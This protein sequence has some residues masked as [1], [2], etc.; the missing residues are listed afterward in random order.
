MRTFLIATDFSEASRN[1]TRYGLHLAKAMQ[2]KV[3]LL[4][5]YQVPLP[6]PGSMV[7]IT[8]E[9]M[10]QIAAQHM[11][12]EAAALTADQIHPFETKCLQGVPADAIAAYADE[13]G[14]ELIIAGMKG[15]GKTIRRIFGSTAAALAKACNISVLVV[16]EGAA[17]TVPEQ[18]VLATDFSGDMDVH[19]LD[20]LKSIATT[21]NSRLYIVRVVKNKAEEWQQVL[22]TPET[23]KLAV[24][25]LESQFE[26]L[27]DK[28]ITHALNEFSVT[29]GVQL[30]AL[31]PHKHNWVEQLF[32]K[33]ETTDMLFHTHVPLLLL[34][35][36]KYSDLFKSGSHAGAAAR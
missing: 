17:F 20:E 13:T 5:V 9:D 24:R 25:S 3:V 26:Y 32:T 34:P 6:A 1:A 18:V 19:V 16:P 7:V 2:A 30:I 15:A 22:N 10:H 12:E 29:H 11:Q 28:D 36:R 21:F 4:S 31:I 8:P 14:A 33:S 35:E 23:L 27:V